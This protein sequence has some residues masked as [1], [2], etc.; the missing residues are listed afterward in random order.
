MWSSTNCFTVTVH[1]ILAELC[2]FENSVNFSFPANSSYSLHPIKLK[3]CKYLYYDVEQCIL[4]WGYWTPN[5]TRVM[6]H[7]INFPFPTNSSYSLHLIRLKIDLL[8]DHGMEQWVLFQ[9]YSTPN[10]NRVMPLWKFLLT[11]CFR[12]TPV[13]YIQSSWNFVNTL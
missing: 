2:P 7:S 10:I 1:H 5:I 12:L 3:L 11:F 4:F 8:L 6:P 9:G 13:V